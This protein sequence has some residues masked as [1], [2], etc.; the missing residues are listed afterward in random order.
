MNRPR[1]PL[2]ASHC[3]FPAGSD[4]G[5]ERVGFR[6]QIGRREFD[7]DA[8]A[9][10]ASAFPPPLA[11]AVLSHTHVQNCPFVFERFSDSDGS[12]PHHFVTKIICFHGNISS[13]HVRAITLA[14]T[15]EAS[16]SPAEV[17]TVQKS[18]RQNPWFQEIHN[19]AKGMAPQT[20]NLEQECQG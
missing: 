20:L 1:H 4:D 14:N 8:N 9:F 10:A 15:P 17:L 12:G 11:R 3:R 13:I 18:I 7:V 5:V 6:W 16:A 19:R 2:T